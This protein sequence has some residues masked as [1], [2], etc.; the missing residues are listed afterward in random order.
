MA[1]ASA[2]RKKNEGP[3]TKNS[4][5]SAIHNIETPSEDAPSVYHFTPKEQH[6]IKKNL[7]STRTDTNERCEQ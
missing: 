4:C 5:I 7:I 6:L 3:H 1:K 2:L